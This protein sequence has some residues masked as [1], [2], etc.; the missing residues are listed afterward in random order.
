MFLSRFVLQHSS[1]VNNTEELVPKK[2]F[3]ISY[4]KLLDFTQWTQQLFAK[5]V[6]TKFSWFSNQES[7]PKS[8]PKARHH[9]EHT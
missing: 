5:Y 6:R 4:M 7:K 1:T 8:V 2:K 3:N 9:R